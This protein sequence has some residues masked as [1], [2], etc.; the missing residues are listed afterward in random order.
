MSLSLAQTQAVAA[1]ADHLYDY[2]PGSSPW[3]GTYT[4][5]SAAQ[6]HGVGEFWHGGS[7]LPALTG[8][9]E[10]TLEARSS[11]FCPLVETIVRKGLKYRAKKASQ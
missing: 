11:S 3:P 6:E 2:L 4:F 8:L 1:L 10:Q 5:A 7:K 9:L